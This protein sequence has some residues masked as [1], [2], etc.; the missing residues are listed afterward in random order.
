MM[1]SARSTLVLSILVMVLIS[2]MA[3]GHSPVRPDHGEDLEHATEVGDPLKSWAIY[4][5]LDE[6]GDAWYFTFEMDEGDRLRLTMFTPHE[7]GFEPTV[8][9]MG[10]GI[11]SNDTLPEGIEAP[12][13]ARAMVVET[14]VGE[15]G[16]EPFT[17]SGH[18][19][20][21]DENLY[22]EEEGRYYVVVTSEDEEG[23]FGLA[24]GYLEQFTAAEWVTLPTSILAIYRWEGQSWAV[25]L[26]PAVVYII[27]SL[28]Y[29]LFVAR[30]GRGPMGLFQML[31]LTSGLLIG[32]WGMVFLFQMMRAMA[33][34]GPT[35]AAV[36]S[37]FFVLVS[38]LLSYKAI[39]TSLDVEGPPS[40]GDRL[41][42]VVVGA[43]ALG[44]YSGFIA[45]PFIALV[46]AALP[47]GVATWPKSALLREG[48]VESVGS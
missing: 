39:R 5:H 43:V 8:V 41:T 15:P 6:G 40:P 16:F 26:A 3:L 27:A 28:A 48:Q 35:G 13:G 14:T 46:A 42:M 30:K 19:R 17:P 22:V 10:P 33:V 29:V 23:E 37:G 36:A 4:G 32:G 11:P 18:Y 45:G 31:S 2:G 44:L 12:E 34:T 47:A 1:S 24:I 38:L 7:E 21:L 20:L 9:V 25:I